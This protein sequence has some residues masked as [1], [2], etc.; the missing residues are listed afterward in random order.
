MNRLL[1]NALPILALNISGDTTEIPK[2]A[3][4]KTPVKMAYYLGL[5]TS[6]PI[7][8]LG[9]NWKQGF[10]GLFR[11][12]FTATPKLNVWVGADYHHF[13]LKDNKYNIAEGGNLSTINLTGD[14]KINLG[15]PGQG[16]NP[17]CF[18]GAGMAI[19]RISDSNYE[20]FGD[21]LVNLGLVSY[22]S[23]TNTLFEFGGGVEYKQM[24]IHAR[25]VSVL[26]D[27]LTVRYIPLTVG[28]KF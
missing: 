17:F 9:D 13:S 22:K 1:I 19:K 11:L 15:T 2:W 28:V 12:D 16:A 20:I 6:Y 26:S 4:E 14:L 21:T 8:D 27:N 10:H 3:Q 5:G 24:F 25:Y 7:S 23:E 18:G